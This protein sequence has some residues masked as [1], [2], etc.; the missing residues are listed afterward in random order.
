MPHLISHMLLVAEYARRTSKCLMPS[1]N[2]NICSAYEAS[3]CCYD[4][5]LLACQLSRFMPCYINNIE[6]L[7]GKYFY[8]WLEWEI[9]SLLWRVFSFFLCFPLQ[10]ETNLLR[11]SEHAK[12][13]LFSPCSLNAVS[14][15]FH[16]SLS[17]I[18]HEI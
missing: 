1:E 11:D 3:I 18:Q 7:A 2:S 5:E 14:L 10:N 12:W 4:T 13:T 15:S 8:A 16:L 9:F 17:V 6:T